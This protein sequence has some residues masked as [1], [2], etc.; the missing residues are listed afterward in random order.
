MILRS[1]AAAASIFV[2]LTLTPPPAYAEL[3]TLAASGTITFNTSADSSLPVGTPWTFALTYDTAA[4]DF[5][6]QVTGSPDPTFGKFNNTASPPALRS[7]HYDAAG[8]HV[9]ID[10]P[11]DFGPFS[12]LDITFLTVNAIDININDPAAFPP[13]AGGSVSFHADFNAFSMAPIFASDAPPTSTTITAQSFDQSTVTLL[14][15]N[16]SIGGSAITSFA[17]RPALSAD[18]DQTGAVDHNDLTKWTTGFGAGTKHIQG[19]ANGDARVD[20]ND[21]LAWQREQGGSIRVTPNDSPIPEPQTLMLFFTA[22]A[23]VRRIASP[24]AQ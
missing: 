15:P 16:T 19:D 13:L 22:W 12:E 20:G 21:F 2:I 9:A 3:F 14:P 18:F 17:I 10:D 1:C 6:F 23:V 7:F 24:N 4:P 5:D 11:A 8:Y